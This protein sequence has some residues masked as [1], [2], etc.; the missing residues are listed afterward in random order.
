MPSKRVVIHPDT[1]EEIALA[2]QEYGAMSLPQLVR[3]SEQNADVMGRLAL[4][5][6][7]ENYLEVKKSITSCTAQYGYPCLDVVAD[8]FRERFKQ[9]VDSHRKQYPR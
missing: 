2:L 9:Y 6:V 5:F 7:K 1:P 4:Q 3:G 8:K